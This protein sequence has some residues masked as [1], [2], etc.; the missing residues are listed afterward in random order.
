MSVPFCF[1]IFMVNFING[2]TNTELFLHPWKEPH[3]DMTYFILQYVIG[4]V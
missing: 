4:F 3:L 1:L 2:I